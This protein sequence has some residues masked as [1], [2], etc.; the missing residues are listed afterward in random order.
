MKPSNDFC[1]MGLYLE[2]VN[3]MTIF[4]LS[5]FRY[6]DSMSCGACD[7][8]AKKFGGASRAIGRPVKD[9]QRSLIKQE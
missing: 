3:K 2:I 7:C 1:A 4:A 8:K 5:T 6:G 9:A